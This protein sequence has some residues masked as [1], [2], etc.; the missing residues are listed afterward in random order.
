MG[1]GGRLTSRTAHV[2]L[3]DAY[4]TEHVDAAPGGDVLLQVTDSGEGMDDETK[5]HIFD[6][7]FTTKGEGTGLGLATVYGI[8]KQSGGHIWL[9]S[10]A[11][12]GTT[13]KVYFPAASLPASPAVDEPAGGS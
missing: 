3:D 5:R 8:V 10:E 7:F 11:G 1:T 12:M 4:A 13:F 6:P 2:E 9:Y